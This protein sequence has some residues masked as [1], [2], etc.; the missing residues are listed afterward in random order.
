M[1]D[2]IPTQGAELC[3]RID[4]I[5]LFEISEKKGGPTVKYTVDLKNS[6]GKLVPAHV[7]RKHYSRRGR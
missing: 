5:F 4:S 3:E 7:F 2:K 1:K 6:P